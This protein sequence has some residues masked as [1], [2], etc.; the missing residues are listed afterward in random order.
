MAIKLLTIGSTISL[1]TNAGG[2]NC[3]LCNRGGRHKWG[4]AFDAYTN[5]VLDWRDDFSSGEIP[6]CDTCQNKFDL[7]CLLEL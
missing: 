2:D 4:V 7:D 3:G 1:H 5:E 6:L